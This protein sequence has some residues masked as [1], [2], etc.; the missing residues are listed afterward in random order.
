MLQVFLSYLV[1][2]GLQTNVI[3][4]NGSGALEFQREKMYRSFRYLNTLFLIIEICIISF[5]Y[6]FLETYLLS[7]FDLHFIGFTIVVF[8]SGLLNLVVS[9]IW[10]KSSNF[11]YYLYESSY[12]YAF[13]LVFVVSV[14]FMLDINVSIL[15]FVMQ[16]VAV[17][18]VIMVMNAIIGF[19]V[20]SFNRGY[21]NV[22]FRNVSSRLFLLAII[23]ILIYYAGFLV[24]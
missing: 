7:Q 5:A 14:V 22:N 15:N 2:Y 1:L 17:M 16:V 20:R 6:Y 4:S 3:L 21:L 24:A 23:S 11:K 10:R 8:L 9:S 18:I 13:D 12:S 19:F